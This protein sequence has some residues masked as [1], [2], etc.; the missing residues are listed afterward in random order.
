MKCSGTKCCAAR[1]STSR[2]CCSTSSFARRIWNWRSGDIVKGINRVNRKPGETAKKLAGW[3]DEFAIEPRIQPKPISGCHHARHSHSIFEPRRLNQI[4][5]GAV[6]EKIFIGVK[7]VPD[8]RQKNLRC[9]PACEKF[10]E[11]FMAHIKLHIP[12]PVR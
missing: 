2:A 8:C 9:P 1:R 6:N 12:G 3:K 7:A 11:H 10:H 4:Y 5:S